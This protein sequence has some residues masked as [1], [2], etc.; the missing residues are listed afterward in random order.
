MSSLVIGPI[1]DNA[2][3][4]HVLTSPLVLHRGHPRTAHRL[5]RDDVPATEAR[6]LRHLS[7]SE[8]CHEQVSKGVRKKRELLFEGIRVLESVFRYPDSLYCGEIYSLLH[9]GTIGYFIVK[10]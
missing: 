6:T 5:A 7:D 10:G 1:R 4:K 8:R 3:E 2:T 9:N